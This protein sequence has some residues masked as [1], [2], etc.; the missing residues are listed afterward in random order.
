[1]I[2][3][4]LSPPRTM[5]PQQGHRAYIAPLTGYRRPPVVR[6]PMLLENRK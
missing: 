1:M 6:E 2:L 5:Q 3:H 4:H